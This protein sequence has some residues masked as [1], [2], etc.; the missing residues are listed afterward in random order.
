MDTTNGVQDIYIAK[1]TT[2]T[3]TVALWMSGADALFSYQFKVAF[4]TAKFS[5]IDAQPDF[6][7]TGKRNLLT[8]NSGTI[9]GIYQLQTNPAA[10]DTV[11]F[12]CSITGTNGAK[13][14]TGDG[15]IGVLYLKSKINSGDSS[16]ITVVQGYHAAFG[17]DLIPIASYKSGNYKSFPIVDIKTKPSV[18]DKYKKIVLRVRNGYVA[19]SIPDALLYQ[20]NELTMRIFSLNGKLLVNKHIPVGLCGVEQIHQQTIG[21]TFDQTGTFLYSL[22]IGDTRFARTVTLP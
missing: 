3:V 13:S 17:G 4:D 21:T 20:N 1:D 18:I 5:F 16:I 14:V 12:S 15:L 8:K 11:E 9:I 10:T 22:E 7:I 6:G 2:Q 19:F